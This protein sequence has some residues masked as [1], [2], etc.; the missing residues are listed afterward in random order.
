MEVFVNLIKDES[1]AKNKEWF[2]QLTA[3]TGFQYIENDKRQSTYR[4]Q[5]SFGYK[6][7]ERSLLN[8]YANQSS[9]ASATAAGFTFTEIGLR[10]KWY[11]LKKPIF[12]K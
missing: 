9:I 11:F 10:F 12:R 4:L 2:Y 8:M 6:F 5:G 3:A 7:S 1:S